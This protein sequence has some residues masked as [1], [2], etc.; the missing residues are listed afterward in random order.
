M[1]RCVSPVVVFPLWSEG[2]PIDRIEITSPM[3]EDG[4]ADADPGTREARDVVLADLESL[5]RVSLAG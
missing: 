4:I 5:E 3:W 2:P 1:F